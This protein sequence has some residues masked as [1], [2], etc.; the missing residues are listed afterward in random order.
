M[1]R[2]I[3]GKYLGVY[4]VFI[5]DIHVYEY[6]KY[7]GTLNTFD[8]LCPINKAKV[9]IEGSSWIQFYFPMLIGTL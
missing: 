7:L 8:M 1:Q 9:V 4:I 6:H 2:V 3:T 5:L